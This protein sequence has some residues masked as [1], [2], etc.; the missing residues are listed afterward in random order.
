MKMWFFVHLV[1]A[2]DKKTMQGA[3][4]KKLGTKRYSKELQ[5]IR[6][7]IYN[8]KMLLKLGSVSVVSAKIIQ[9]TFTK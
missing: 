9:I 7:I 3:P 6:V 4:K 2:S 5:W 8:S 1:D